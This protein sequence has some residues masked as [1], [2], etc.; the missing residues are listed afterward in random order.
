STDAGPTSAPACPTAPLTAGPSAFSF[1]RRIDGSGSHVRS[2]PWRAVRR[3]G[4]TM[5]P[6]GKG[7]KARLEDALADQRLTA[8]LGLQVEVERKTAKVS[9]QVPNERYKDL[10]RAVASGING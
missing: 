9:G 4:E 7:A 8:G 3:E 10:V 5:W 1:G 6:F 2:V